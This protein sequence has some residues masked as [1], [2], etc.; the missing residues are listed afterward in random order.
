MAKETE[1]ESARLTRYHELILQYGGDLNNVS[2]DIGKIMTKVGLAEQYDKYPKN[3]V[4]D[5]PA[6]AK[7]EKAKSVRHYRDADMTLDTLIA[8]L[9]NLR[10]A[11]QVSNSRVNGE[12]G[13]FP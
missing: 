4:N 8:N 2:N 1:S 9:A 3:E 6:L 11:L 12:D 7:A 10:N 5:F 13:N